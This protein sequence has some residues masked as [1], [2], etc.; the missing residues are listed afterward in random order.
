MA[1]HI[2]SSGVQVHAGYF[3]VSII[4]QTLVLGFNSV[5]FE[6]NSMNL[7]PYPPTPLFIKPKMFF[8]TTNYSGVLCKRNTLDLTIDYMLSYPMLDNLSKQKLLSVWNCEKTLINLWF[9]QLIIIIIIITTI[10]IRCTDPITNKKQFKVRNYKQQK[11]QQC[12]CT[13]LHI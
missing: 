7:I 8:Y 12:T 13:K 1:N 5:H 2:P 3:H 6:K 4:H 10:F 9:N 11:Q